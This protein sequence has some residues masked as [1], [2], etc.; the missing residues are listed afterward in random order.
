MLRR[1]GNSG[2]IHKRVNAR[3]G[4]GT[5]AILI[6]AGDAAGPSVDRIGTVRVH[7]GRFGP[8]TFAI[9]RRKLP[10]VIRR[11]PRGRRNSGRP[12]EF[13]CRSLASR[14]RGRTL[15][16][17]FGRGPVGKF[18]HVIRRLA[19]TCTSVNFGHNEDIV[20]GVLGC[21]V[22]RRGLVIGQSGRCCFKCAPTRV[23]LF[24]RRRWGR[25]EG[26]FDLHPC[27]CVEGGTGMGQGQELG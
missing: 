15:A 12:S 10:R 18:S 9:G 26:R 4:G 5:R 1:G 3:V 27:L 2:G 6:V 22:G 14:R 11:A 20:V 23:S 13:A 24:R 7:R 8:F 25:F 19:R 16:T 17:T 21:L